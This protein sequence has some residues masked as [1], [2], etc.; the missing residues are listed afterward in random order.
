ELARPPGK[1]LVDH[2]PIE[3]DDARAEL[4]QL[5]RQQDAPFR[6]LLPFDFLDA[7]GRPLNKIG[8]PDSKLEDSPVI[9][10][11]E[12]FWNHSGVIHRW[13]ELIRPPRIVV[14]HSRRA[15]TRIRAHQNHPHSLTKIVG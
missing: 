4:F 6:E 9:L 2:F 14:A 3:G 15:V 7:T 5:P 11:A 13:P 8:H 12:W 1:F 10:I